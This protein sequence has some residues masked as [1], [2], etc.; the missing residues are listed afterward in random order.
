MEALQKV[1]GSNHGGS[2]GSTGVS[3]GG[4]G[5]SATGGAGSG[6]PMNS[7]NELNR[8]NEQNERSIKVH[9]HHQ[10]QRKGRTV[11][12]VQT[13]NVPG[14]FDFEP[15]TTIQIKEREKESAP[16]TPAE[17]EKSEERRDPMNNAALTQVLETNGVSETEGSTGGSY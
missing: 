1:F 12:N 6:M 16:P 11:G 8:L 4:G 10:Q 3:N 15:Y 17:K 5:G 14:H 9:A 7:V 13:G 2:S